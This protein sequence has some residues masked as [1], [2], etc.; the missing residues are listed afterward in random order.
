M[1]QA[2][3]HLVVAILMAIMLMTTGNQ[4]KLTLEVK[5]LSDGEDSLMKGTGNTIFAQ[6][7][8]DNGSIVAK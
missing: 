4:G 5:K 3:Y 8:R 6:Y 2:L 7:D 1:K